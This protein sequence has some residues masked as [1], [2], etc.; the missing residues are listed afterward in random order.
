MGLRES[1][2]THINL[3]TQADAVKQ[4]FL[5]LPA[6]PQ[7][8]VLELNGRAVA[9]VLP[10]GNTEDGAPVDNGNLAAVEAYPVADFYEPIAFAWTEASYVAR[11]ALKRYSEE[12]HADY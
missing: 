5:A 6:D 1:T 2:V 11:Q 4:F 10:A 3:D 8:S 9:R 12:T 7:G